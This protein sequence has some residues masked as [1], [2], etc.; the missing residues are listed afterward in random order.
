MPSPVL[1]QAVSTILSW[2]LPGHE[3]MAGEAAAAAVQRVDTGGV[4]GTAPAEVRE[5]LK[6]VVLSM[7]QYVKTPDYVGL[8]GGH[9]APWGQAQ[10]FMKPSGWPNK[11]AFEF[12]TNFIWNSVLAAVAA[13]RSGEDGQARLRLAESLHA[14]Q[15]SFSPAHVKRQRNEGGVW[16]VKDIQDYNAQDSKEHEAGDASFHT[17]PGDQSPYSSLAQASVLASTVLLAYFIQLCLG[18]QSEA[19]ALRDSLNNLYLRA[20]FT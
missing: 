3:R 14:L 1:R 19:A 18:R 20:D 5:R 4:L 7:G 2:P 16:V 12:G 17:G 10:H 11:D 8:L 15:D 13:F 6:G 9:W